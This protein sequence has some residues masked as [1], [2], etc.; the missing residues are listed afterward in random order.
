VELL[1]ARLAEDSE[2]VKF[3]ADFES[4]L[5]F[6]LA[7]GCGKR[8]LVRIDDSLG[9]PRPSSSKT[10]RRD[11][12]GTLPARG[13]DRD[14]EGSPRYEPAIKILAFGVDRVAAP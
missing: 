10:G 9:Y 13:R 5:F 2:I 6:E 11:G 12:R 7:S 3:S 1:A 14:K 8:I 4:G